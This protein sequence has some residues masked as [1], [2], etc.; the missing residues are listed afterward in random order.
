MGTL[1]YCKEE[2]SCIDNTL[3]EAKVRMP[4]YIYPKLSKWLFT[5]KRIKN[6]TLIDKQYGKIEE[7]IK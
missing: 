5:W 1:S 6:G 4:P 7:I 2:S 3:K